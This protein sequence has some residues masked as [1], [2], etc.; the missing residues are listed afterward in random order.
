[1]RLFGNQIQCYVCEEIGCV[2]QER[3]CILWQTF[4]TKELANRGLR[5]AKANLWSKRREDSHFRLNEG[6]GNLHSEVY[7]VLSYT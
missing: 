5:K 3:Q 2:K 1:M 6:L 7:A 4:E